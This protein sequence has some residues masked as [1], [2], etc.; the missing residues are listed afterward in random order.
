MPRAKNLT[1]AL[2]SGIVLLTVN[3]RADELSEARAALEKAGIRA[4]STGVALIKEGE[5]TRELTKSTLLKKNVLQSERDLKAAQLQHEAAQR[6]LTQLRQQHMQLSAQLANINRNDVTLNNRLVGALDVIEGQ[7]ELSEGQKE[8]SEEQLKTA[9]E[10]ASEARE[11]YIELVLAARRLADEIEADYSAKAADS[12]VKA[13]LARLN[14]AAKKQFAL[15]PTPSFQANLRRLKQLEDTVL[16]ESI[17]LH[18]DGA[19]T[20]RVG[21]VVNGKH[22]QE[23]VL[24]SGASLISLPPTVAARFGLKPTSK[25]PKIILELADG[26]QIEGRLMKLG[27]VRVGKFIVENVECAVLG[28]EAVSAEPLLG[29]SFLEHF[30][31]EIDSA[32]K[33]LTMVKVS[34]GEGAV[35]KKDGK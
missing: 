13:A 30:K 12:E 9:R 14:Q 24:D 8:R 11:N 6:A 26:R 17:D 7:Y 15:A 4:L 32:A 33:K 25:D 19:K 34:G 31:F 2:T 35:A 28:D 29:M 21:V 23:M 5:F 3:L 27:T 20:L 18:D 1:L 22:Q 16:S 10:K